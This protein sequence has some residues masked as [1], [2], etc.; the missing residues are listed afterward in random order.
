MTCF[1]D[2]GIGHRDAACGCCGA[3]LRAFRETSVVTGST[4]P[5]PRK[6]PAGCRP[7]SATDSVNGHALG[8]LASGIGTQPAAARGGP[9]GLREGSRYDRKPR[10]RSTKGGRDARGTSRRG[11]LRST[12]PRSTATDSVNGLGHGHGFIH[13]P[14]KG[15][16]RGRRQQISK[17]TGKS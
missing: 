13:H 11:R 16:S 6:R 12:R 8:P 3:A 10:P 1:R 4:L 15:S 5:R 14:S 2:P 9:A 17:Y 7:H